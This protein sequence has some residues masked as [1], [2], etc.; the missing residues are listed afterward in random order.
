MVLAHAFEGVHANKHATLTILLTW[1]W[2]E[3]INTSVDAFLKQCIHCLRGASGTIIPRPWGRTLW[4][5]NPGD[6]LH[7]DYFAPD[8]AQLTWKYLLIMVDGFTKF[9]RLYLCMSCTAEEA[10]E[11]LFEWCRSYNLPLWLVSDQGSHFKARIVQ[12]LAKQ[13]GYRHHM[14]PAAVPWAN[15]VVENMG[16]QTLK[17]LR[18]LHSEARV[19]GNEFTWMEC[20]ALVERRLNDTNYR[21]ATHTPRQVF[22]NPSLGEVR[23]MLEESAHKKQAETLAHPRVQKEWT[24]LQH[25]WEVLFDNQTA[26]NDA[27]REREDEK[28]K[29]AL[30]KYLPCF[31]PGD[32]VCVVR[33]TREEGEKSYGHWFGPFRVL[34]VH[35][36]SNW[37]YDV[38]DLTTTPPRT[39][40][41]HIRRMKFFC[42]GDEATLEDMTKLAKL[43]GAREYEIEHISEFVFTENPLQSTL[44][45]KY[46]GFEK[47]ETM[48]VRLFVRGA[49]ELF[50]KVLIATGGAP[51][52]FL[53]WL[54][55]WLHRCKPNGAA[56]KRV[57]ERAYPVLFGA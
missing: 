27:H 57:L 36:R 8:T 4:A 24:E 29:R 15:G 35:E 31:L 38:Q 45:V 52:A 9:T 48:L 26:A 12:N 23:P 7:M 16:K 49:P 53:L 33:T 46:I 44:R 37:S 34:D 42:R 47:K 32:Y 51:Q 39:H 54:H 6:V 30:H 43:A 50:V 28:R 11:H 40:C 21:F 14:V 20:V 18:V 1:C 17:V 56:A 3:A 10:K 13:L 2:W 41:V 55:E 5:K 22:L 25:E 19:A